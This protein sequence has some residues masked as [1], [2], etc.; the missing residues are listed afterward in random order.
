MDGAFSIPVRPSSS[1]RLK[2]MEQQAMH[3][4]GRALNLPASAGRLLVMSNRAA[5]FCSMVMVRT[6]RWLWP[7]WADSRIDRLSDHLM[8][9]IGYVPSQLEERSRKAKAA[10][11]GQFGW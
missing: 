7:R 6:W 1:V 11:W 9:D 4:I 3:D 8:R 5:E 2:K 10:R